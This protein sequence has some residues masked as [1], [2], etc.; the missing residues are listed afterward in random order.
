MSER[1]SGTKLTLRGKMA[2]AFGVATVLVP[3]AAK[4][5]GEVM[6]SSP[7]SEVLSSVEGVKADDPVV[8][9]MGEFRLSEV[10]ERTTPAITDND[11][12]DGNVAAVDR[13]V[14]IV[15]PLV[16]ENA[17][18]RWL[19]FFDE[20]KQQ[21]HFAANNS[22]T[23]SSITKVED[24]QAIPLADKL[25]EPPQT[26]ALASVETTDKGMATKLTVLDTEGNSVQIGVVKYRQ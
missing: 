26:V 4:V 21:W 23:S 16:V 24:G 13:V 1:E 22:D 19:A 2:V 15:N 17:G 9:L 12:P 7:D 18:N 10:R 8:V 25:P 14:D 6:N 20:T 3:G 5:A 11:G